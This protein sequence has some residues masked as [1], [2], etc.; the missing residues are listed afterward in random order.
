MK[1][2]ATA[3]ARYYANQRRAARARLA[4]ATTPTDATYALAE[5]NEADGMARRAIGMARRAI[6]AGRK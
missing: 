6:A 1:A 4:R 2:A 3:A 5:A